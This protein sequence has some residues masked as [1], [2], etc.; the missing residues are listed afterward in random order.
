[1]THSPGRLEAPLSC[2]LHE[3]ARGN[4]ARTC[5]LI[6][7]P[8]RGEPRDKVQSSLASS[9]LCFIMFQKQS[10]QGILLKAAT[11]EGDIW[12]LKKWLCC[13]NWAAEPTFQL[14]VSSLTFYR[15]GTWWQIFYN[16]SQDE[17]LLLLSRQHVWIFPFLDSMSQV[18]MQICLP[19][20]SWAVAPR[21]Q[22]WR[23]LY[24][25]WY[26][27]EQQLPLFPFPF[28]S[29]CLIACQQIQ[30]LLLLSQPGAFRKK[31]EKKKHSCSKNMCRVD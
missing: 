6:Q 17:S 10:T 24:T 30:T 3:G 13:W 19:S 9:E 11:L 25:R 27:T 5:S 22:G 20:T 2:C 1:M 4:C 21:R 7:P 29:Q 16:K 23:S 14:I 18:Q 26:R 12:S 15:A 28:K 31:K 8:G